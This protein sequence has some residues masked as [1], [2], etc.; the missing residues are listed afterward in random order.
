MISSE[1]ELGC[2]LKNWGD[3]LENFDQSSNKSQPPFPTA[4]FEKGFTK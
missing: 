4:D 1:G 3:F 2:S